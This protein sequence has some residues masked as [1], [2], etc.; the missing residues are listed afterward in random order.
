MKQENDLDIKRVIKLF[1][2]IYFFADV[3]LPLA[4]NLDSIFSTL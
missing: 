4:F 1:K 2:F 3:I